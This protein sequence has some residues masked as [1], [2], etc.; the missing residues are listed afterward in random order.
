MVDAPALA[1]ALVV[2]V[3]GGM[4]GGFAT[5]SQIKGWY[6]TLKK[7]WWNP[8]NWL[9]GPVWTCLYA[10]MGYASYLVYEQGGFAKQAVPLGVYIA[11]LA[12]NFLWTPLFFTL[13]R[14]DLATVD[15]LA[16]W[17]M[18]VATIATFYPV[19]GAW[20][21]GLLIPYLAWVSY[22]SALTIWIW[23]NNPAKPVLVKKQE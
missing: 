6:A 11:Q 1:V 22:A 19:I 16:M 18:I 7:P 3:L 17:G 13:H 2:P 15:I 21:L 5:A 12:L 20:A 9:F 23:R 14:F 10:A 8:P 4:I